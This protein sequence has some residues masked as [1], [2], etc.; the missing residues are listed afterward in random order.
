MLSWLARIA[1]VCWRPVRRYARMNKDNINLKEFDF[2]D[3][4]L[5]DNLLWCKDLE[6]HSYGDFSFAVVQA[7]EVIEDHSQVEIGRDAT[8]VGVYDGHGGPEASRFICDHLFLHLMKMKEM[9]SSVEAWLEKTV[10]FLRIF[11]EGSCCLVG[12]IWRGTLYVANVGDSRAVIGSLGRSNKIVAEQLTRDHNASMEEVRQELK[13]LH[14]DDSHIVVMKHGVWRIKGIIQVSRSI[15]DAYLKQPEFSLDPSFPRF[16]LPEPIRRPVLTAE[17]SVYTRVLQPN[18][19]FLI[20]A[21]DGLWEHLTNQEAA[22]IVHNNP[23]DGVAKRLLRTALNIA[24]RK[25]EMRYDDLK[26][27]EK[28]VRRFFHDDITVDCHLRRP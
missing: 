1:L 17:P 8:F 15:G 14:P 6:K 10:P 22:E 2:S 23:R 27:V 13:S 25:R 26:K 21:S 11:L 28:G 18:D 20:F 3:S 12:V 7:N 9:L 4:A 24:A 16:H 19:K 5:R